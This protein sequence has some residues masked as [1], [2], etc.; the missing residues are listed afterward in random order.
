[1]L[2]TARDRFELSVVQ[3]S[4]DAALADVQLT[5]AVVDLLRPRGVC[6]GDAGRR[7]VGVL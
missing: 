1:M 6:S 5:R 7:P 2:V 3:T 4:R